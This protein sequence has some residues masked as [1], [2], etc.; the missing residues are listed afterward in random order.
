[1]C[2]YI[3]IYT[4]IY[5]YTHISCDATVVGRDFSPG[6]CIWMSAYLH[7]KKKH[8]IGQLPKVSQALLP[9]WS[10]SKVYVCSQTEI[11][12]EGEWAKERERHPD[13]V[14]KAARRVESVMRC[15]C[16]QSRFS[17]GDCIIVS[18]WAHIKQEQRKH[19]IGQLPTDSQ[20]LLPKYMFINLCS[21]TE[22][23]K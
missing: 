1:M 23:N 11:N 4:H 17:P 16:C 2:A 10:N 22:I 18:G 19:M 21:Q 12:K 5:I 8:M 3:H 6:D 15:D 20:A 14:A 13:L 9:K 7:N